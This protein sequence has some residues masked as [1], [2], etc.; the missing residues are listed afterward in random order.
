[1][2]ELSDYK[3][4][5]ENNIGADFTDFGTSR[6]FQVTSSR[7]EQMEFSMKDFLNLPHFDVAEN[8]FNLVAAL[9][10]NDEIVISKVNEQN[11]LV[12]DVDATGV[13]IKYGDLEIKFD[14]NQ[15]I[16]ELQKKSNMFESMKKK[17]KEQRLMKFE[18]VFKINRVRQLDH[19]KS[20]DEYKHE[21]AEGDIYKIQ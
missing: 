20:Y 3:Q 9:R 4:D 2:A 7:E 13:T 16:E 10:S 12:S 15:L 5:I 18:D 14:K 6:K 1:M 17:T 11:I 19:L 21:H 8:R